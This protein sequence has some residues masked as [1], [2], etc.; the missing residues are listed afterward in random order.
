MD[1]IG[2]LCF[3]EQSAPLRGSERDRVASSILPGYAAAVT[4][5]QGGG[6]PP[7][8]CSWWLCGK[9]LNGEPTYPADL[10]SGEFGVT[11]AKVIYL[12]DEKGSLGHIFLQLSEQK[13]IVPL[14]ECK[15]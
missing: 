4:G 1:A 12:F 9:K 6:L 11:A 8:L 3:N 2:F 7:H 14:L 5:V 15:Y 10:L 13:L